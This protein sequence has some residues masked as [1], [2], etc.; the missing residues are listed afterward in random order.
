[1]VGSHLESGD[2]DSGISFSDSS[3]P[4]SL[5]LSLTSVKRTDSS[6][7]ESYTSCCYCPKGYMRY[8][9][10]LKTDIPLNQFK[11]KIA[12]VYMNN[13]K[14]TDATSFGHL[15]RYED[16]KAIPFRIQQ[17]KPPTQKVHP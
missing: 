15:Y 5:S 9:S 10:R 7:W 6:Q 17:L 14:H 16:S 2:F 11:I 8:C 13:F 12:N 4:S 3:C 1:M